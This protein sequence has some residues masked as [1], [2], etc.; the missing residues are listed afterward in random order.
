M[1][2]KTFTQNC[3]NP[4][5]HDCEITRKSKTNHSEKR[6]LTDITPLNNETA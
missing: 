3:M 4:M 5:K 6:F 2:E 1:Y